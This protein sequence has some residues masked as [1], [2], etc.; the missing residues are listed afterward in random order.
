MVR[1]CV[2]LLHS[3]NHVTGEDA[4]PEE[5]FM[6]QLDAKEV[7]AVFSAPFHNFLKMCDEPRG[8][9]DHDIP[10]EPT[11]WYDGVWTNWNTTWWRSN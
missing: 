10:G 4:D 6:P 2:A 3:Y 5:A 11:D 9:E 1:P 7:A 8:A